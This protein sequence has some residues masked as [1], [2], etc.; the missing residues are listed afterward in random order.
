MKFEVGKKYLDR[1]GDVYRFICYDNGDAIFRNTDKDCKVEYGVVAKLNTGASKSG[2]NL[3][4]IIAEYVEPVQEIE[5]GQVWVNGVGDEFKILRASNSNMCACMVNNSLIEPKL[6]D[7]SY[8]LIRKS[9]K[10]YRNADGS[11]VEGK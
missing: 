11:L 4:D 6:V 1:N 2:N 9:W 8:D 10:L 7:R 3:Y 5:A